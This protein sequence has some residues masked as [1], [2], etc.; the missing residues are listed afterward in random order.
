MGNK[1]PRTL[2]VLG[3]MG[4][5]ATVDFL[6]KLTQATTA[7]HDQDHIPMVVHFCPQIPD[8]SD[9]LAAQ[10]PSPLPSMIAAA[11]Q[12]ER[13]GAQALVI[14]CNTAHAWYEELSASLG[15]P[16]LH[17]VDAAVAQI[18]PELRREPVG[19]LATR[20]TLA[21]GVY[22]LRQPGLNWVQPLEQEMSDWVMPAIRALKSGDMEGARRLLQSAIE[23]LQRRGA[24]SIMLGCTEL[25][26]ARA[27]DAHDVPLIDAT[28][29]LALSAIRWALARE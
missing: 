5:L 1:I 6:N 13:S 20:G 14:P 10:G 29:A 21:S 19:L 27:G 26:L 23:S 3:G 15:I 16:L 11:R 28:Q 12:I 24:R 8:R 9:A 2:G 7:T 25:P 4:P 22:T 17:I 18:P